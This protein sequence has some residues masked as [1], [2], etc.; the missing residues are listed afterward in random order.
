[1]Y[2]IHTE[3]GSGKIKLVNGVSFV[4][5]QQLRSYTHKSA[6]TYSQKK[7]WHQE[8]SRANNCLTSRIQKE[9]VV[10]SVRAAEVP[11][12]LSLSLDR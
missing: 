2:R 10:E 8:T 4:N 6:G 9:T 5:Q 7:R 3:I 11:Q 12:C 1:M